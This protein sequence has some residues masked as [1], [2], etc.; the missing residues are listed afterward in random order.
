MNTYSRFRWFLRFGALLFLA[1]LA[2]CA[3]FSPMTE[4]PSSTTEEGAAIGKNPAKLRWVKCD[5]GNLPMDVD[6]A[7]LVVPA[8]HTNPA[9]GKLRLPV[10]IVRSSNTNPAPDPVV[11]LAGG[12]GESAVTHIEQ[13]LKHP[14]LESRDLILFDQRGSGKAE[15]SLNCPEL[16]KSA[17]KNQV[18]ALQ[19][20]YQRLRKEGIN[21]ALFNST[22]SAADLNALRQAL[23]IESWNLMGVSYGSRLAL[24]VLRDYPES[25]R[26]VILDSPYPPQVNAYEEMPLNAAQAIQ[27]LL[28]QC[29]ADRDCAYAYPELAQVLEAQLASLD[30]N[31]TTVEVLNPYSGEA[32]QVTLDGTALARL[33]YEALYYPETISRIPNVIY[34]VQYGNRQAVAGLMFPQNGSEHR[35]WVISQISNGWHASEGAFF[36]MEC[37]DEVPFNSLAKA[38]EAVTASQSVL[39]RYFLND[40]RTVFNICKLWDAGN[41]DP[42]E[43][44]AVSSSIPVLILAGRFDP[45]TPPQWG[46]RAVSTL[47]NSYFYIFPALG[48]A[49]MNSDPPCSRQLVA[50]FL[51]DPTSPPQASCWQQGKVRFWLP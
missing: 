48:H 11:Y 32:R 29:S 4:S 30:K 50:Q 18:R 28:E 35:D 7:T 37:R 25:V 1:M 12:P 46:E 51:E 38:E 21:P 49:V 39:A 10:T 41:A 20:C 36:S 34:E 27:A 26:S 14:L 8:D 44:Q 24:T 15:P 16:E 5:Y 31:P 43:N 2:A 3:S 9:S 40:V 22:Q 47:P 19:Q 17:P 33:I 42:R 23:G 13:W 45:V 6:C